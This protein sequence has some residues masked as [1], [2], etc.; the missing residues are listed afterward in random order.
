MRETINHQ[1]PASHQAEPKDTTSP[2]VNEQVLQWNFR[3][4]LI[5]PQVAMEIASWRHSPS[6]HDVG[7]AAFASTGTI[8]PNLL[9]E[10]DREINREYR[11]N[12]KDSFGIL[13]LQ[14]LREYVMCAKP[15]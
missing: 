3:G 2:Y 11:I 15:Y 7:F 5:H 12:A 14:A 13:E 1:P 6:V 8:L 10:I 4:L 9:E